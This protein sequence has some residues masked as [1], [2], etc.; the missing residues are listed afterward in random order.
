MQA[1]QSMS[2]MRAI[3]VEADDAMFANL[4]RNLQAYPGWQLRKQVVGPRTETVEYHHA[5]NTT[6]SG[7]LEP[8]SLQSVWPNLKTT[9][10]QARQ[11]IA[12]AE[13][14]QDIDPPAN[15]LLVDCLPALPI[16]QGAAQQ[17]A[18]FDVIA[19]RVLLESSKDTASRKR[20]S[21][22]DGASEVSS[23]GNSTVDTSYDDL[24]HSASSNA[25]LPAMHALGFRCLAIEISRHPAIG[26]SLFVR[27]TASL[28]HE[29]KQQLTQQSQTL[30][31]VVAAA[32]TA[33]KQAEER[34]AQVLQLTQ[35]KAASD[36][37]AAERQEQLDQLQHQLKQ[38]SEQAQT[39]TQEAKKAQAEAAAAAAAAK[40]AEERAGQVQLLTQAQAAADKLLADRMS[41]IQAHE[42]RLQQLQARKA[43]TDHLNGLLQAEVRKAEVQIELLKELFLREQTP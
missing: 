14:Q 38:A 3:L 26:H 22:N 11:A 34:A 31:Q 32:S 21:H 9:H 19:L 2:V 36:K 13:L 7:L 12:L 29:L 1:L 6:E 33:A 39:A 4:Q 41:Q 15:W 25:V 23:H 16:I 17:L 40:Q 18:G 5:S 42:Q 20:D 37:L 10:K 43:E 30:A 27:D 28:A 8:E 35:A 24:T